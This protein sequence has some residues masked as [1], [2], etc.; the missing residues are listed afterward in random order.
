MPKCDGKFTVT[1]Q[2]EGEQTMDWNKGFT[3]K[4]TDGQDQ[5]GVRFNRETQRVELKTNPEIQTAELGKESLI[6]LRSYIDAV[7]TVIDSKVDPRQGGLFDR[8][9]D[10]TDRVGGVS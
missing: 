4:T 5:L 8:Y 10:D 3:I 7:I 2:T 9:D 1:E 6:L